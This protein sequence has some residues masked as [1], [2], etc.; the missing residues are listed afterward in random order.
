MVHT[1]Q[2]PLG[3]L[4]KS[5]SGTKSPVHLVHS[6]LVV[7]CGGCAVCY[8]YLENIQFDDAISVLVECIESSYVKEAGAK[9]QSLSIVCA[10]LL[11]FWLCVCFLKSL[12]LCVLLGTSQNTCRGWRAALKLVLA[13]HLMGFS[14]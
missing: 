6:A 10:F 11:G 1:P 5:L 8:A 9:S 7:W 3:P 14:H 4:F 13:F 2:E 12:L